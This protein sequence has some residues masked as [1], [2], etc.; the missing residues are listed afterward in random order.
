MNEEDKMR[1]YGVFNE[2]NRMCPVGKK[3]V[4]GIKLYDKILR[5]DKYDNGYIIETIHGEKIRNLK[6]NAKIRYSYDNDFMFYPNK[7]TSE[8]EYFSS[9][10]FCTN[11]R[12]EKHI[13][14]FETYKI[15]FICRRCFCFKYQDSVIARANQLR[16]IMRA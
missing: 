12:F 1:E 15:F 3:P 8:P 11:S 14:T 10:D 7:F 6:K 4:D 16:L 5:T 13:Y 9:C 2:L